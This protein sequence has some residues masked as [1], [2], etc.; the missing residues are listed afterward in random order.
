ML[1]S[2]R[3]VAVTVLKPRVSEGTWRALQAVDLPARRKK[4]RRAELRLIQREVQ[5]AVRAA[6]R[7]ESD[8]AARATS[9]IEAKQVKPE[10]TA[11]PAEP[12]LTKLARQ[13]GT[14]KWGI[15]RYTP[16]Y[17]H[18]FSKFV[19][20]E[21]TLLEIGIGGYSRERQ[22]GASLRMWKAFFPKAEIIGLDIENKS[23]VEEPR[24]KAYQGSQT[25]APLLR[26]IVDSARN[27]RIVIDDG[28]HRPEH[29]RATFGLLFPLLPSGA[30]YAIEDTQTSYWPKWGGSFDLDDKSTTMALVKRL[31]DGLNYEEFQTGDYAP[32]YSDRTVIAV[33][34]YHNLVIIEKGTNV[35]GTNRSANWRD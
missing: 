31:I 10:V 30:L 20:D 29:V 8:R 2:F 18:H 1:Q 25:N 28:S 17:E 21:F 32:S 34:C 5:K 26:T 15:H 7:A 22:G 3:K 27:L 6:V 13:F 33:H 24:I 11:S 19:D 35:E 4:R 14:D 16:H 9:I 23:F 12:R